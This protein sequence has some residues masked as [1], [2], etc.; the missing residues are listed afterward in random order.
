M[1]A[2]KYFFIIFAIQS[3]NFFMVTGLLHL[4][5]VLRYAILIIAL[6]AIIQYIRSRSAKKTFSSG[7]KKLSMVF[8]ILADIQLLVGGILYFIGPNAPMKYFKSIGMSDIMK[9]SVA[10]FFT[11]EHPLMMIISLVLIHIGHASVKKDISSDRK[12][13]KLITMYTL[14]LII[15]LAAVPWPFRELGRGW[16]PG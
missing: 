8:M 4:H 15:I 9:D 2:L 1:P 14:A 5:S 10:R 7:D 6:I 12:Y 3:I 16:L 11:I 13:K